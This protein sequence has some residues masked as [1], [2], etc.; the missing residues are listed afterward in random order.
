M[1]N[2]INKAEFNRVINKLEE[3]CVA[4]NNA[5]MPE[6]AYTSWLINTV[7]N[8]LEIMFDDKA[9]DISYFCKQLEFGRR[10]SPG[11]VRSK[12]GVYIDFSNPETLYKHLTE[13][14]S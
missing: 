9:K 14:S 7:I 1:H 12:S 2:V 3:C 4:N 13:E 8:L 10:Y 11:C 6:R 5:N